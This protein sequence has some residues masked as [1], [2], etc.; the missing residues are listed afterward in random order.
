M[1]KLA[2]VALVALLLAALYVFFP[3]FRGPQP[4]LPEAT[5]TIVSPAGPVAVA[6]EVAD[7]PNERARG[8]SF[9]ERL[10]AESGMLFIFDDERIQHFWMKDTFIPLDVIFINGDLIIVHIVEGA[11]PCEGVSCPL[12][13]SRAP[14][15]YALEVNADFVRDHGIHV[16]AE[17][18][19]ET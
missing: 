6:V 10:D 16:G 8:L 1:N 7:D 9:R 18:A 14:V 19:I 3:L 5:V 15:L 4:A 17:V 12:F 2:I 11:M 13:S